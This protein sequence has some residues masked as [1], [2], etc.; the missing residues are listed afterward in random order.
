MC[1]K[2]LQALKNDLIQ[3]GL[4]KIKKIIRIGAS[5]IPADYILPEVL[6]LFCQKYP[7]IHCIFIKMTVV[8]SYNLF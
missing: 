6:P 1:S 5:T 3:N 2:N 8:I 4:K 7:D